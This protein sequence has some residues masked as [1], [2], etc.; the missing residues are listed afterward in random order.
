M[1]QVQ[2][3]VSDKQSKHCF[4]E[5][6]NKQAKSSAKELYMLFCTLVD[7]EDNTCTGLSLGFLH[8]SKS[9]MQLNL[10]LQGKAKFISF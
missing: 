3:D 6:L 5:L 4:V 9:W 10:F 8:P 7:A 1:D 2:L